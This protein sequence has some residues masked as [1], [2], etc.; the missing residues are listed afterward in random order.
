M[1]VRIMKPREV[2][3]SR[4]TNMAMMSDPVW[5]ILEEEFGSLPDEKGEVIESADRTPA[6]AA[7]FVA[8]AIGLDRAVVEPEFEERWGYEA[9]TVYE[10]QPAAGELPSTVE[11]AGTPTDSP[12]PDPIVEG[13]AAYAVA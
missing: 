8:M 13:S 2:R 9:E 11:S 7:L 12:H 3:A 1:N 4:P 6:A 10:W 5:T